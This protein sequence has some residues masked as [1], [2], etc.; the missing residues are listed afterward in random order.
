MKKNLTNLISILITVVIFSVGAFSQ[1][2]EFTYQGQL[3]SSSAPAS[4]N[5]DFE[6]LLFDALT[7]GAQLGRHCHKTASR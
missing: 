7:G 5:F 6:F 1:T 2:T 4:G 3:Q